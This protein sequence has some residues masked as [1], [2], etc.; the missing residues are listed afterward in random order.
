MKLRTLSL[1]I[2]AANL[3]AGPAHS[4]I[5]CKGEAGYWPSY[6]YTKPTISH[7]LYTSGSE[8]FDY[9]AAAATCNVRAWTVP[10]TENTIGPLWGTYSNLAHVG[11]YVN[12]SWGTLVFHEYNSDAHSLGVG[13]CWWGWDY[14]MFNTPYSFLPDWDFS[15]ETT[16]SYVGMIL[17]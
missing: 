4:A 5:E 9:N 11:C 10:M 3:F 1:G 8:Y 14:G 7:N 16:G 17:P 12:V 2:L 15:S 6:S 13:K